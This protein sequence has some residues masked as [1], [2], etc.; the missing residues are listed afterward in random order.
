MRTYTE[1]E[2]V[3]LYGYWGRYD[4]DAL[5]YPTA[6]TVARFRH[7]LRGAGEQR[8]QGPLRPSETEI[9]RMFREQ[10]TAAARVQE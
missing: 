5:S 3:V 6:A 4:A 10:E 8:G 1:W 2:V 7:W 9:V